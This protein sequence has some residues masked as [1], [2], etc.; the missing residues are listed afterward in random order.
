MIVNETSNDNAVWAG[1][2]ATLKALIVGVVTSALGIYTGAT[3]AIDGGNAIALAVVPLV[4]AGIQG[5]WT[6]YS[7]R[8]V[9]K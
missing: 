1:E 6:R 2:P 8:P 7:V 5:L 3:T 9:T 4:V